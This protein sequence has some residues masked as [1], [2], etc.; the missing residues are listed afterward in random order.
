MVAVGSATAALLGGA[1]AAGSTVGIAAAGSP[2]SSVGSAS[3]GL[4]STSVGAVSAMTVGTEV[5]DEVVRRLG[6]KGATAARVGSAG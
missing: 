1:D 6:V 5:D 2:G 3:V 4:L